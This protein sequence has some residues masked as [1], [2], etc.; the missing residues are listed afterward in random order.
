M[1]PLECTNGALNALLWL[2]L[3][4]VHDVLGISDSAARG[5]T[6]HSV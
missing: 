1:I 2:C 3:T 5:I 6:T 4:S